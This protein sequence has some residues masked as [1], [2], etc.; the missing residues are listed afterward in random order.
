MQCLITVDTRDDEQDENASSICGPSD[1]LAVGAEHHKLVRPDPGDLINLASCF[2]TEV[3]TSLQCGMRG[4]EGWSESGDPDRASA[5]ERAG[6]GVR[7]GGYFE[8]SAVVSGSSRSAASPQ[9]SRGRSVTWGIGGL[10]PHFCRY[11]SL[12]ASILGSGCFSNSV[13]DG[14]RF[15][16]IFF[17]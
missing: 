17:F 9:N 11:S 15:V 10:K 7:K 3:V 6:V 5:K 1:I 16:A 4:G 8:T 14:L 13:D 12:A 2:S